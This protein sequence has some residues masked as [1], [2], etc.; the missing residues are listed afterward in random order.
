[1]QL[2]G[3][4]SWRGSQKNRRTE[5]ARIVKGAD[6]IGS[7]IFL[8]LGL[9]QPYTGVIRLSSAGLDRLLQVLG[10]ADAKGAG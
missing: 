5:L 7:A 2:D 9:S 6:A 3:Q 4:E 8:I 1:L 10:E